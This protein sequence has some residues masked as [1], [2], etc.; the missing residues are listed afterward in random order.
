MSRHEIDLLLR[1]GERVLLFTLALMYNFKIVDIYILKT[2]DG[3]K[4][5]YVF[6]VTVTIIW[7]IFAIH[8]SSFVISIIINITYCIAA[9]I[10]RIDIFSFQ[11]DLCC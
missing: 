9:R 11:D 7:I 1:S 2:F 4:L 5:H 10:I 8:C 3:L 6:F